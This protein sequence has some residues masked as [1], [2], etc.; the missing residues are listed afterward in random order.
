MSLYDRIL[1]AIRDTDPR[2][3]RGLAKVISLARACNA[4]LELFHAVSSPLFLTERATDISIAD[5]KT[6]TLELHRLRLEKL[7]ARARKYGVKASCTVTWDHPAHDAI[8]RRAEDSR[9]S[10]IVAQCHEGGGKRWAMHFTDWELVRTSPAPVLLMRDT[11][12]YREPVVLAAVDPVRGHGKPAD[13]DENILAGGRALAAILRGR[14]HVVHATH[15]PLSSVASETPYTLDDFRSHDRREFERLMSR[16][17]MNTR[18]GHLREGD[19]ARVIQQVAAD[20]LADIVVM[21]AV[22]RSGIRRL[23][24]GNTAER[25]LGR[26]ACDVLVVKPDDFRHRVS[27]ERQDAVVLAPAPAT[28]QPA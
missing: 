4:H 9:A 8:V 11:S 26:L 25:V 3:A 18:R 1:Y 15:P 12:P 20:T 24:I 28:V 22:S 21:G 17:D 16:A 5:L 19:P 6:D 27:T 23:F 7:V 10:L 13:L 14:L 2:R